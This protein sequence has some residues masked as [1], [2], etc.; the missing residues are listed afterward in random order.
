MRIHHNAVRFG[1]AKIGLSP[2]SGLTAV[3]KYGGTYTSLAA[4]LRGG[5]LCFSFVKGF[6]EEE[7][8]RSN[9]YCKVHPDWLSIVSV[10]TAQPLCA[11]LLTISQKTGMTE[12]SV[13]SDTDM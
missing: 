8:M 6:P 13:K 9:G 3:S 12:R 10:I 7:W 2:V 1:R 11:V 4:W 5:L